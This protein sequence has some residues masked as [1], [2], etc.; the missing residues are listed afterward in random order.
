[1]RSVGADVLLSTTP[2]YHSFGLRSAHVLQGEAR[3]R[4]VGEKIL[5]GF[6]EEKLTSHNMVQK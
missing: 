5:P 2:T 1:M 3:A 4:R 6:Y